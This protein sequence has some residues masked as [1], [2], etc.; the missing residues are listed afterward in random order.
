MMV[1]MLP[2]VLA[3]TCR[4]SVLLITANENQN[5][6]GQNLPTLK[7]TLDATGNFGTVGTFLS[8]NTVPTLAQLQAFDVVL[9]FSVFASFPE[10]DLGNVL[11]DYVDGGGA[12]ICP[13]DGATIT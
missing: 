10:T 6:G 9:I 4:P 7:A 5:F 13:A 1:L 2:M 8:D 11:A 12:F 3:S